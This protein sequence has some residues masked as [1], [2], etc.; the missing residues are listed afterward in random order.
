[1][2]H[3]PSTHAGDVT[4][5]DVQRLRALVA[6]AIREAVVS[7][8]LCVAD[9]DACFDAHPIH[10]MS[11]VDGRVD[12]VYARVDGTAEVVAEA[13]A[14]EVARVRAEAAAEAWASVRR[15][16]ESAKFD[17]SDPN[18][19]RALDAFK[20]TL[21]MALRIAERRSCSTSHDVIV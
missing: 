9:E 12:T 3:V 18:G 5:A 8:E 14:A 16:V 2:I 4:V 19:G 6:A 21:L 7:E 1:M 17:S 20:Q 10:L 15:V 11:S 13:V